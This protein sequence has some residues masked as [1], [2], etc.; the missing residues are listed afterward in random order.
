MKAIWNG[1]VL[2]ESNDT[3]VIEG[4]HYFPP[5]TLDRQ[6][7]VESETTSLCPWKGTASYYTLIVNG[8]ENKDAAWY[9]SSP[10]EA[11][12]EIA[13]YVAFWRGVEVTE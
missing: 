10:K 11:A 12:A 13:G 1:Q 6:L 7:F 8:K 4:N 9:Y 5:S 3:I 2:A